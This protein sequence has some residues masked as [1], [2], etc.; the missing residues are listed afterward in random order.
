MPEQDQLQ[1]LISEADSPEELIRQVDDEEIRHEFM[2][3]LETKGRQF[4]REQDVER[5]QLHTV[6][7]GFLLTLREY[8]ETVPA[9]S[10]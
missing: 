6:E 3:A 1:K 7:V 2:S 8:L 4:V 5:N 9:R 10:A